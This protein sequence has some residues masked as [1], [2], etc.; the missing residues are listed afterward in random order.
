MMISHDDKSFRLNRATIIRRVLLCVFP[1]ISIIFKQWMGTVV[2]SVISLLAMALDRYR[3]QRRLMSFLLFL[4]IVWLMQVLVFALLFVNVPFVLGYAAVPR[5][6]PE[7]MDAPDV[8]MLKWSE[9]DKSTTHYANEDVADMIAK[10]P[11]M[12]EFPPLGPTD[13]KPIIKTASVILAAHNEHKYL[14]RTIE[15]IVDESSQ[16]ELV[17]IIIVDDA[18]DPPLSDITEKMDL[19]KFGK[20][21]IRIIRHDERQGLIRSKT[22]G[23]RASKGDLV[24]FLDAH[25]KPEPN[26][27]GP[28]FRHTNLNYKRVVVPLIPILNGD[29][30]TVDSTAVGIKM[31]FDWGL[32]FNWFDDGDDW[33]PVMSGGLLAITRRYWYESGEYDDKMLYWGGENIEQSVRIWLCGGEIVVARDSRVSHVFRPSFPYSIDHR[34]VNMNKVRTVEVWFDQYR[35]F[36][37]KADPFARTLT[38]SMTDTTEREELKKRLQC[39]PFQYFVDRFR[40]VFEMKMMLPKKHVAIKDEISGKCLKRNPDG[41]LSLK[42]CERALNP[43][44]TPSMR[45]I[46]E[47]GMIRPLKQSQECLDANGSAGPIKDNVPIITYTCFNRNDQQNNWRVEDGGIVWNNKYCAKTEGDSDRVVF[48]QCSNKLLASNEFLGSKFFGNPNHRFVAIDEQTMQVAKT[49]SDL[50]EFRSKHDD[51]D[52]EDK[53]EQL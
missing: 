33:V 9:Y 23:A 40:S 30:W 41:R 18:S 20:V 2:V 38:A 28:L 3:N 34:Q 42:S 44:R 29:T 7:K 51:V 48:G 17:E 53:A 24:I 6:V 50:N 1:I 52:E 25:V 32:G 22:V 5:G 37:Y 8:A 27:L 36:F 49:D 35:E 26:W 46:V 15:S 4:L 10:F 45:F 16:D 14:E 19:K 47:N 13:P 39:K 31:M 21:E 43:E 11:W 12:A